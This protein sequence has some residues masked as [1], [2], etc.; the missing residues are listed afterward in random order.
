MTVDE[1]MEL[2]AYVKQMWPVSWDSSVWAAIWEEVKGADATDGYSVVNHLVDSPAAWPTPALII[3][4]V[5]ERLRYKPAQPERAL[6]SGRQSISL[7]PI[8]DHFGMAGLEEFRLSLASVDPEHGG[9]Y[10]ASKVINEWD[11]E[12][13]AHC[14][15][16]KEETHEVANQ[17]A[18]SGG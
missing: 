1:F 10:A 12:A 7:R 6:P 15:H 8:L 9:W 18:E 5:R 17:P 4:G 11:G 13:C 14:P 3:G 16:E 2:K